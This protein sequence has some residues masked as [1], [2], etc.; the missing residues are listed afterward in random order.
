MARDGGKAAV[1]MQ[2]TGR[3]SPSPLS[4]TLPWRIMKK[5]FL[6]GKAVEISSMSDQESYSIVGQESH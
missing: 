3:I 5:R 6:H 4:K 2:V 1:A